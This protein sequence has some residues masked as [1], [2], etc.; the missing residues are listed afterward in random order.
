MC[1]LQLFTQVS[2]QPG[3]VITLQMPEAG[4]GRQAVMDGLLDALR[5]G[6]AAKVPGGVGSL[7]VSVTVMCQILNDG[8]QL[9][10]RAVQLG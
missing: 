6:D 1:F 7:L 10:L 9:G 2:L 8:R 3:Q 4:A 5:A